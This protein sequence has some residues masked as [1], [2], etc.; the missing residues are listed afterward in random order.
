MLK[1]FLIAISA[2]WLLIFPGPVLAI[3]DPRQSPNNRFGIHIL[4]PEDLKPAA[5]LVNANGDWGYIT[6]VLRLNDLDQAKWQGIFDEMRRRH[7]IPL[8]RLATA[9]ENSHWVKP[10][11][12]DLDRWVEFLNSLNWVV[13]NRYVILFNEPNHA[14]EWG[15]EVNPQEYAA[16]AKQLAAKLKAASADF[17]ILP[18]GLD[19]A[20]PTVKGVTL[21]AVEFWRQMH[22]VDPEIFKIF[23]GWNSHSYPNP[24]FAGKINASGFGTI[25]SYLAEINYLTRFGLPQNLPVFITETGWVNTAGDLTSWYR[26]AFSRVWVEANLIAVT[27]FVLNYPA[28]P[29]QKFSWIGTAHYEA[30]A[31]L[32]KPAGRP[33]QL[34]SSQVL[35]HNLPDELVAASVYRFLVEFKNTGQSIWHRR[36]FTLT[37]KSNLSSEDIIVGYLPETE[38]GQSALIELVFKTPEDQREIELKLQLAYQKRLFGETWTKTIKVIPPPTVTVS[39][40]PLYKIPKTDNQYRL[41]IYDAENRL[42]DEIYI[43]LTA[44]KSGP[45]KLYNLVPD[46]NYRLVLLKPYYLPRQTWTILTKEENKVKFKSLLPLD[47]NNDGRLSPAD[48]WVWL[49]KPFDYLGFISQSGN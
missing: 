18:A 44:G 46:R 15:N 2:V 12:E 49:V 39:A 10:K 41:L 8:V 36:D 5:E 30:V 25:K 47:F 6:I 20:A 29:F 13:Q 26:Q 19:T 32:P 45:I 23:D 34:H 43:F 37:L 21:A 42:L 11:V 48:F 27:P 3:V 40:K 24:D 7:L 1:H 33:E 35:K 22:Q 17:F 4:E 16:I 38:P 28:V 9:P 31:A 14:K